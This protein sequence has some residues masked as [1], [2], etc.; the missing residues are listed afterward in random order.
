M[1]S[2]TVGST[3]CSI[4]V[5]TGRLV[6]I[7]MPRSP[8]SRRHTQPPNWMKKGWSRPSFWRMRM[9]SATVAVS[10]AMMAAGSPGER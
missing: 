9:M 5:M 4:S 3:R 8:W 2:A 10:P 7:E 6:K 1:V